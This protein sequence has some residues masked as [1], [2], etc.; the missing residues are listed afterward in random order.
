MRRLFILALLIFTTTTQAERIPYL[1]EISVQLG[2]EQN[3]PLS[4]EI[5]FTVVSSNSEAILNS[6]RERSNIK[7]DQLT[8]SSVVITL[9]ANSRSIGKLDNRYLSSSFVIDLEEEST[10][11]FVSGYKGSNETYADIRKMAE[12]VRGYITNPT[13]IHSFNVASRTAKLRSGDCTEYAVLATA[14]ARAEKLPSKVVL[15]T[16]ILEGNDRVVSYGHAWS[17][18]WQDGHWQI[19]DPALYASN[20]NRHFYLPAMEL[21]NEGPGYSLDLVKAMQLFPVKITHLQNN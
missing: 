6:L 2:T 13:Y 19:L 8:S 16:V 15:G 14:L 11:K 12:Y 3:L 4:D 18:V 9:K 10:Q 17:E 5:R 7:V 21:E 1:A 20:F